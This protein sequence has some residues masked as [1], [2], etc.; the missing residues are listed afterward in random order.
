MLLADEPTASL[1]KHTGRAIVDLLPHLAKRLGCAVLLVTRENRIP[2]IA[3]RIIT[4][5][6]GL[7]TET[8]VGLERLADSLREQFFNAGAGLPEAS[9]S[10]LFNLT[11]GLGR[12][13]HFLRR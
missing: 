3:D 12:N 4:L 11:N 13:I 8:Q 1:D 5:E 6:D 9:R 2:D 10:Y 7:L